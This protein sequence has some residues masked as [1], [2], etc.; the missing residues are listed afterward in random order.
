MALPWSHP[1]AFPSSFS[2]EALVVAGRGAASEDR[3]DLYGTPARWPTAT[4]P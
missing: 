3:R 2:F 4:D 1:L